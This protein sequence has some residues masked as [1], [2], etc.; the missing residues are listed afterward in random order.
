MRPEVVDESATPERDPAAGRLQR[1]IRR[2]FQGEPVGL[3]REGDLLLPILVRSPEPDRLDLGSLHDLQIWS[4]V[5]GRMIPLRQVVR[6]FETAFED[7]VVHRRNRRPHDHGL[8]G[9]PVEGAASAL[10]ARVRPQI[11]ALELP[12]G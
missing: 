8:T 10:F 3:Y 2:A 7:D 9:D 12:P 11:E 1:A 5:A 6:G 4:P